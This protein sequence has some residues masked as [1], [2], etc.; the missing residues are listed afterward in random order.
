M[1]GGCR[2]TGGKESLLPDPPDDALVIMNVLME[3]WE[4]EGLQGVQTVELTVERVEAQYIPEGS[5]SGEIVTITVATGP[6]DFY[7]YQEMNGLPVFAGQFWIPKGKLV[8]MDYMVSNM[9][10]VFSDHEE[11]VYFPRSDG[12][13]AEWATIRMV[14][15]DPEDFILPAYGEVGIL[16]KASVAPCGQL[17][18]DVEC[19]QW[20]FDPFLWAYENPDPVIAPYALDRLMVSYLPT[21]SQGDID[22]LLDSI[23]AIHRFEWKSGVKTVEIPSRD[24]SL[25]TNAYHLFSDSP[26]NL[27]H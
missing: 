6:E 15:A 17:S 25:I 9:H 10:L 1:L 11:P 22:E 12:P 18:H 2:Q 4:Q 21:A 3:G 26:M 24:F 19:S 20:L 14:P 8:E 16:A 5:T 23:N 13:P 7:F 27:S